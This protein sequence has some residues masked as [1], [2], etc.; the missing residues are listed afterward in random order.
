MEPRATRRGAARICQSCT[1]PRTMRGRLRAM[2]TIRG[3][4]HKYH[5]RCVCLPVIPSL[6]NETLTN[7]NHLNN[8]NKL[9]I[10]Y[11]KT[12]NT[13][14]LSGRRSYEMRAIVCDQGY[15]SYYQ[16]SSF[17]CYEGEWRL[18]DASGNYAAPAPPIGPE[19]TS[20]SDVIGTGSTL[21][22]PVCGQECQNGGYCS[23]PNIC[24]CTVD[25][26]GTSC[27]RMVC[28]QLLPDV[29][30]GTIYNV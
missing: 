22:R 29:V 30:Q 10:N 5:E 28:H 2:S 25:Y 7:F 26:F 16:D 9:T 3:T 6:K 24:T 19:L 8:E 27:E 17:Q 15:S 21:C 13:I 23:A 14:S 11:A 1:T 18:L 20:A 12:T 4:F